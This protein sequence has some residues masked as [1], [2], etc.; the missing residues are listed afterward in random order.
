MVL[1]PSSPMRP[2]WGLFI[3]L[4]LTT[5]KVRLVASST[6]A[7]C[8]NVSSAMTHL[9]FF[10]QAVVYAQTNAEAIAIAGPASVYYVQQSGATRTSRVR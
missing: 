1:A 2:T 5:G 3:G 8:S 7:L 10:L 6:S 9:M 4:L